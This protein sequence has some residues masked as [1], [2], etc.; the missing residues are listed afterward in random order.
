MITL[1]HL[2]HSRSE[3]VIWLMEELGLEYQLENLNRLESG[4]APPELKMINPLG[5]APVIRDGDTVLAESGAI[6]EYII[7][8]YG[9]GRLSVPPSAPGYARYLYWMHAVEGTVGPQ[10]TSQLLLNM[11]GAGRDDNPV[12][13]MMKARCKTVIEFVDAELAATPYIAGS[14]FTAADILLVYPF[15]TMR[16]FTQLDLAP[17]RHIQTY[18]QRIQSRPAYRK[19]MAIAGN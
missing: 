10:I 9:G 5:S 14:E 3:R 19:A 8:R 2:D 1:Y 12:G 11:A 15:T 4:L 7:H 17:Y 16:R 18:L 13:A 6:L